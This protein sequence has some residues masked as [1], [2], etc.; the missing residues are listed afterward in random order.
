MKDRAKDIL[1]AVI[2]CAVVIPPEW[3]LIWKI[4]T[5]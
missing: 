2:F 1:I 3:Y 5:S 4:L